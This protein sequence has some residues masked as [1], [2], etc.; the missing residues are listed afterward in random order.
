M[1]TVII[2]LK[3]G[4]ESV[5]NDK[6][7]LLSISSLISAIVL[8]C[9]MGTVILQ[10]LDFSKGSF[11]PEEVSLSY[12]NC[13]PLSHYREYCGISNVCIKMYSSCPVPIRV[14]IMQLSGPIVEE[15]H[16]VDGS[17]E[18]VINQ[19]DMIVIEPSS[20]DIDLK[21]VVEAEIDTKRPIS[22]EH[23]VC[24][25]RREDA[26][27]EKVKLFRNSA[28][29]DYHMTIVDN[30]STVK[31]EEDHMIS[32]IRMP[33][34]GGTSGFTRGIVEGLNRDCTHVLLNDDDAY[35][36]PETVFRIIQFLSV[37]SEK[38]ADYSISGVF[39][40]IQNTN[41]VRETGG[42]FSNGNRAIL[43]KGADISTDKG[44]LDIAVKK[45]IDYSSWT[46]CCI[47][48]KVIQEAGLPLPL[49]VSYDDTE[50]GLRLDGRFLSIP[51]VSTWHPTRTMYPLRYGYYDVRNRLVTAAFSGLDRASVENIFNSI[52][53]EIAAYR[54]DCAEEM[55]KGV[56][57]FLKGPE[58][59]FRS[60]MNG[61]HQV[62]PMQ[63]GDAEELRKDLRSKTKAIQQSRDRRQ[64][65]MNG[66]LLPS[67]GDI[68]L[69]ECE[70]ETKYF[71]RI[72]KVLYIQ[73]DKGVIRKRSL[74]QAM[75][76]TL[77][78]LAAKRKV[79]SNVQKLNDLFR[80]SRERFKSLEQWKD[81]WRVV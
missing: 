36:N 23:V 62:G 68:E 6:K 41:T 5:C 49:F 48:S 31:L 4:K 70:T 40:D 43:N 79:L 78:T 61:M 3:E 14:R 46:C 32:L 81:L 19:G 53:S 30:G 77:K 13:I 51:G 64:I 75:R 58:F 52:L 15:G 72:G 16:V 54:Y 37:V 67:I 29:Q 63:Y 59:V 39:L 27:L 22:L 50:Y 9:I 80:E 1:N 2:I 47:P 57:D 76:L 60:C 38:Y 33:N 7:G 65:T 69:H 56:S 44:L 73:G 18:F 34:L 74:Y 66:L 45:H 17:C 28:L 25:Y 8:T 26:V 21:G 12:L 20:E 35:I 11:G 55:L 42:L 10:H 71:Y 24:T